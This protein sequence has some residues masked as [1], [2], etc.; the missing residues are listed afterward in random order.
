ML[1]K[2]DAQRENE[3]SDDRSLA[4]DPLSVLEQEAVWLVSVAHMLSCRV[5]SHPDVQ[6]AAD[7]FWGHPV[8]HG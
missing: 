2:I 3:A 6:F 5:E 7:L 4:L 1:G 8:C